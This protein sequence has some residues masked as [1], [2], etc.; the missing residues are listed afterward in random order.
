M[1]ERFNFYDVYGYL[2]PGGLLLALL[3]LPV[4]LLFGIW[5]PMEFGSTLFA[6]GLSYIAGQVLQ[7]LSQGRFSS[8]LLVKTRAKKLDDKIIEEEILRHPSDV[9]LD[10]ELPDGPLLSQIKLRFP[11]LTSISSNTGWTSEIEKCRSKAFMCCRSFLVRRKAAAYVEQWE[12]MYTLMRGCAAAFVLA[13]AL[14][15]GFGVG[16][17]IW[18][19]SEGLSIF[20]CLPR[21]GILRIAFWAALFL[22]LFRAS[23]DLVFDRVHG[24]ENTAP[25][26]LRNVIWPKDFR[27]H[28]FDLIL[29]TLFIGGMIAARSG[30]VRSAE[31][32]KSHSGTTVDASLLLLGVVAALMALLCLASYRAFT[33]TFANAVYRDFR[34]V[35]AEPEKGPSDS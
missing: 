4:G 12:G 25:I 3:W 10:A 1:T 13:A 33:N 34:I 26:S 15:I 5:P 21:H 35:S 27:T 29:Y 30:T 11:E 22:A 19:G 7:V 16:N 20:V 8:K 6:V 32:Y 24:A 28:V 14:Y 18:K 2:L 17:T 23:K 31:I 9:L